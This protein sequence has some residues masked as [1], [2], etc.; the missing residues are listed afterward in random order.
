[1]PGRKGLCQYYLE[2]IS[3]PSEIESIIVYVILYCVE[4]EYQHK[5]TK[6]FNHDKYYQ[7]NQFQGW[8]SRNCKLLNLKKYKSLHFYTYIDILHIKYNKNENKYFTQNIKMYSSFYY[9]WK[10]P[11]KMLSRFKISEH[12]Q[13]FYSPNFNNNCWCITIAPRGYNEYNIDTVILQ[14]K[15]LKLPYKIKSIFANYNLKSNINNGID[16]KWKSKFSYNNFRCKWD[17]EQ[18][19]TSN[20]KPKAL[21]KLDSMN[22]TLSINIEQ[23]EVDDRDGVIDKELWSNYGIID[24]KI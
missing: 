22:V 24:N 6:I 9:Q 11:N 7:R 16:L 12:G 5:T 3:I 23:V 1:M 4:T 10:I 18:Y 13:H 20:V 8:A 2:L 21:N 14:F 17:D 19:M 15:L